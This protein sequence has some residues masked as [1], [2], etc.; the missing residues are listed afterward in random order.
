MDKQ[1]IEMKIIKSIWLVDLFIKVIYEKNHGY[2]M[3]IFTALQD[4][5]ADEVKHEYQDYHDDE[6]DEERGSW[7]TVDTRKYHC[8]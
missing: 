8:F 1:E 3:R 5:S 7:N 6:M 4:F 2:Q